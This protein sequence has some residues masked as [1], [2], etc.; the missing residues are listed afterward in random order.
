M[1]RK[2]L[3]GKKN[4]LSGKKKEILGRKSIYNNTTF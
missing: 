3:F 2:L 4:G 1:G